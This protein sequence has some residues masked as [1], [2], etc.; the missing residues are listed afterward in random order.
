MIIA[1]Y[2]MGV[3]KFPE[4]VEIIDWHSKFKF[5]MGESQFPCSDISVEYIYV[6]F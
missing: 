1:I 6:G 3:S 4:I 2:D 5:K